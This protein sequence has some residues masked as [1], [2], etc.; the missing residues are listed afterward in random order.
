MLTLHLAILFKA[1]TFRVVIWR[2]AAISSKKRQIRLII[3]VMSYT[4]MSKRNSL[5]N[6]SKRNSLTWVFMVS[7]KTTHICSLALQLNC[8]HCSKTLYGKG[9]VLFLRNKHILD[10]SWIITNIAAMLETVVESILPNVTFH[11]TLHNTVIDM[12]QSPE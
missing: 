7:L 11:S 10:N 4:N 5:T 1:R 12:F 8:Y 9:Q 2:R 6:M 3:T